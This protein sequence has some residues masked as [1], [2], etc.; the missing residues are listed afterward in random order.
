MI[1]LAMRQSALAVG[2][3]ALLLASPVA[4]AATSLC[5]GAERVIF[6]CRV[7]AKLVSLCEAPTTGEGVGLLQYRIGRPG[8]MLEMRYPAATDSD[9]AFRAGSTTLAGG[10]G[11]W[12]EFNRGRYRYVVYSFLI[13]GKGEVAGV[14]VEAEGTRLATLRCRGPAISELG[15]DYFTAA[16]LVASSGEFL[17]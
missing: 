11:A 3:T 14:A 6:A 8:R 7:G 12:V 13:H 5:E 4:G 2:L 17:P 15:P 9:P 16:G 1:L 10:G